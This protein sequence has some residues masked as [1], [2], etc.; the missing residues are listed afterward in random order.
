M[1]E[2]EIIE[3]I[4][5]DELSSLDIYQ[6]GKNGLIDITDNIKWTLIKKNPGRYGLIE[7]TDEMNKYVLFQGRFDMIDLFQPDFFKTLTEDEVITLLNFPINKID[8]MY[9]KKIIPYLAL[10]K[11]IVKRLVEI[12]NAFL[13]IKEMEPFVDEEVTWIAVRSF[14]SRTDIFHSIPD[15]KYCSL[16]DDMW[17]EICGT[18][19]YRLI[20]EYLKRGFDAPDFVKEEVLLSSSGDSYAEDVPLNGHLLKVF[21]DRWRDEVSEYFIREVLKNNTDRMETIK[22][23]PELYKYIGKPKKAETELA[24]ELMPKNLEFVKKQ[25]EKICLMALEKDPSVSKYVKIQ[26]DAISELIGIKEEV[27]EYP[28]PYYLLSACEDLADEGYLNYVTIIEGKDMEDFMESQFSLTFGNLY[29]YNKRMVKDC[30]SYQPITEDE[31]RLLKKLGLSLLSSGIWS[32]DNEN[33]D[34]DE[35]ED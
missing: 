32:F 4:K 21:F 17:K 3:K 31:Y 26:T 24:V 30:F 19:E 5:S 23:Y 20:A 18:K 7:M 10:T 2:N 33:S 6:L 29:D 16:T 14:C 15:S 9:I 11:K 8:Y 12:S 27:T 28:A 34:Y 1:S 13:Y 22:A 35:E 25:S